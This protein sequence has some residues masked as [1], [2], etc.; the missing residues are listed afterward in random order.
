M[1][2]PVITFLSRSPSASRKTLALI[3]KLSN[4]GMELVTD[5]NKTL[6]NSHTI[7]NDVL[8]NSSIPLFLKWDSV[9][10][11][12]CETGTILHLLSIYNS[13]DDDD[14]DE[15][16]KAEEFQQ[17]LSLLAIT[18]P[19]LSSLSTDSMK[20][21]RD[22][23]G[24]HIWEQQ[25]NDPSTKLQYYYHGVKLYTMWK[26]GVQI[27][28]KHILAPQNNGLP[29]LQFPNQ[30]NRMNANDSAKQ[31][32]EKDTVGFSSSVREIVIPHLND[33]KYSH[34]GSSLLTELASNMHRPLTGLYQWKTQHCDQSGIHNNDVF[35]RPLPTSDQDL[36][37]SSPTIVFRYNND[38]N[39]IMQKKE[40]F[41]IQCDKI[42]FNGGTNGQ[43][44]IRH[45]SLTGLDVRFCNAPNLLST[46]AESHESLLAGSLQELQ[47]AHVLTE[48]S[49]NHNDINNMA[50]GDSSSK[51]RSDK[52][53]GLGDCWVEFRANIKQPTGFFK[54]M[55][56]TANKMNQSKNKNDA[57]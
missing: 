53:N 55:K 41:N 30:N 16:M 42:G 2:G 35:F 5:K 23:L 52:M 4:N 38:L 20:L 46:F 51:I 21:A 37:L 57:K 49:S 17:N 11:K 19:S 22:V 13:D 3:G 25:N 8:N 15:S 14:D 29:I 1:S 34:N 43:I 7:K 36:I 54:Q 31:Y 10:S 50:Y 40:D 44:L 28:S 6:K 47:S 48:G 12:C 32:D 27:T 24:F 45:E 9:A 33:A 56:Q 26:L 18:P 39:E